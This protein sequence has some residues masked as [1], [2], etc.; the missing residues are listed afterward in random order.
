MTSPVSPEPGSPSWIRFDRDRVWHPYTQALTA[1]PV[2]P[3]E[4]ARGIYLYT[5]DGR[6]ILDG[7]SS[8]WVNI[9]GHNH[10]R[11]N[12]ALAAQADTLAQVIFAGFTHEPAARL[13]EELTRRTPQPLTRVFYSDDGSTAVEVAIKM[14]YQYWRNRG[15]QQRNLIVALQNAY[16]GD[17]FG[18]MAAGGVP[19][20]HEQFT[21]LLFEVRRVTAVADSHVPA[22]GPPLELDSDA[23]HHTLDGI[24]AAES[25]RI[26]AVIIEPMLQGAGGMV[27]W[28]P[29]FLRHVHEIVARAGTLLIADE[30]LTGFGRTGPFLA[31]EHGPVT[32]DI[33]CLSKA[34]TAGYLPLGATLCTEE[35][36]G[37]FLAE[38]YRRT[39]WHGHSYTGNAL[40]C[41]VGLESLRLFDEDGC[42]ERVR[43]LESLFTERLGALDRLPAV[44]NVR[45]IGGIAALDVAPAKGGGYVDSMGPRLYREFLARNVLL[46]PLGNVLYVMPPYCISD[47]EAHS[48]FDVIEEVLQSVATR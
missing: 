5:P 16:H 35:I 3:I 41:A 29:A 36:Y 31:C 1:P 45:A 47:T 43:R 20:F 37:A 32:P 7:I 6:R 23:P 17:T 30:V 15:E 33:L 48:V 22:G 42:L 9:H 19:I 11:L 28:P 14:A 18:A 38:D 8:W 13:A 10:P 46:R 44:S 2:I 34:L 27:V 4:R 26:A 40:A 24:V 25:D 12:R 39:L 21:D